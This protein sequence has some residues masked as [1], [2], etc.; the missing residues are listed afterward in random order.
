MRPDAKLSC[1]FT[2]AALNE[3]QVTLSRFSKVRWLLLPVLLLATACLKVRVNG[4]I[5]GR[6]DA[7]TTIVVVRH[8]EKSTDD[9]RDPSISA[10]GWERANAL[11]ETLKGAGVGAIYS[12]QLKRT[13]Q[14][15]EPL[16]KK[17][18]LS[19]IERPPT[20]AA[21]DLA[22]EVLANQ[23]G[24]TVLIVGHSN[25][26]PDIVKALSGIE[27]APIADN[28]YDHLYIVVLAPGKSAQVINSR[29][30]RATQ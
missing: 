6:T 8:A 10:I 25:T 3:V 15:A 14:T 2:R 20:M 24:K 26:V 13:R 7:A 23:S 21:A 4:E 9:P 16:A 12:T 22:K 17:L 27:V 11:S 18:G 19:I 28:E 30:G 1:R 29:F 5:D